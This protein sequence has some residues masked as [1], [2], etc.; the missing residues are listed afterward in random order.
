M[1]REDVTYAHDIIDRFVEFCVRTEE[2]DCSTYWANVIVGDDSLGWGQWILLNVRLF[3]HHKLLLVGG[4]WLIRAYHRTL[5][6]CSWVGG[7]C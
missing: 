2:Q 3:S 1:W 7:E 4:G 6:A 5:E